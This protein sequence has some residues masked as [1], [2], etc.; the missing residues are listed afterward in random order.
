MTNAGLFFANLHNEILFVNPRFHVLREFFPSPT[1]QDDWSIVLFQPRN[2]S[3][4]DVISLRANDQINDARTTV[5]LQ[6]YAV[7]SCAAQGNATRTK[8]LRSCSRRDYDRRPNPLPGPEYA[9]NA[10]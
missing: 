9:C 10:A 6:K 5:R 2:G 8:S 4:N 1:L 7:F 3:L